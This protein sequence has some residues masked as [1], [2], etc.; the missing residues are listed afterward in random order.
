MAWSAPMTAVTGAWFTAAQFNTQIRDNL[1]EQEAAKTTLAG[2]YAVADGPNH[3]VMRKAM[4]S[5]IIGNDYSTSSQYEELPNWQTP[6]LTMFTGSA[7][8]VAVGAYFGCV[9]VGARLYVSVMVEGASN[10]SANDESAAIFYTYT[11]TT[12]YTAYWMGLLD[13]LT[14]GENTF[15]AQYRTDAGTGN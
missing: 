5:P 3:L 10:V 1:N 13:T 4:A 15:K 6:E 9:T 12:S 11:S 2:Q 7:A 8:L 14:P